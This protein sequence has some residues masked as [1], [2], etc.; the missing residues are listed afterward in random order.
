M[1]LG[2][3]ARMF[4]TERGIDAKL[5]VI[6]MQG[7]MRGDWFDST[8]GL[9]VNPSPNMRSLTEATLYPGLG[10]TETTNI[11]VGRGTDTPFELVG[12]PWVHPEELARYLNARQI[13][14]VRFVP[15]RFTPAT[16]V[17]A[18]ESCGGVNIMLTDR[19]ALDAPEMGLE[20]ASALQSLYPHQFRIAAMN[21]L[22]VNK[23][24]LDAVAAGEDPRRIA[25]D[26][27]E[28]IDEFEKIR[29][30]YLLY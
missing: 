19:N 4:N 17:Y 10:L 30:K 27:R 18:N 3:L 26:W 14:G 7:W 23:A 1:T 24:S 25:E 15:L 20:I 12:A 6:P 8:G 29:A 21:T 9:W 28:R 2:E 22:M 16:A 13:S 11:S 5:T